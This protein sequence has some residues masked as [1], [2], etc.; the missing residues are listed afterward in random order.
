VSFLFAV[1]AKKRAKGYYDM[2]GNLIWFIVMI[3]PAN[4]ES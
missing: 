1:A 3:L 4:R 2:E